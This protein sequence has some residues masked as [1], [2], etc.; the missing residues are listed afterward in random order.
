MVN[1]LLLWTRRKV[2]VDPSASYPLS[3]KLFGY[4]LCPRLQLVVTFSAVLYQCTM[5]FIISYLQ[6]ISKMI[7]HR[8][9]YWEA[10]TAL[11]CGR[12]RNTETNVCNLQH[13]MFMGE[14]ACNFTCYFTAHYH[15]SFLECLKQIVPQPYP[16]VLFHETCW[17]NRRS[18]AHINRSYLFPLY[19][20]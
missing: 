18:S 5:G 13:T 17:I 14:P 8:Y 20:R 10:W 16:S 2:Q 4:F 7:V 11:C 12:V 15:Q 1:F 3:Q 6:N 9:K 19:T